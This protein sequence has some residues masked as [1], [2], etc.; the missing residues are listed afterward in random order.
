MSSALNAAKSDLYFES[1][2]KGL[3]TP[4]GLIVS[5]VSNSQIV[6]LLN[7]KNSSHDP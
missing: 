1:E 7:L 6:K 2:G 4:D 3:S 5:Q